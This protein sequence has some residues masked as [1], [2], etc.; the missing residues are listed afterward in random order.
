MK[1]NITIDCRSVIGHRSKKEIIQKVEEFTGF[2]YFQEYNE[3]DEESYPYITVS[4]IFSDEHQLGG[5]D[6]PYDEEVIKWFVI[7]NHRDKLQQIF[8]RNQE[9]NEELL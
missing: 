2:S 1:S 7:K 4:D 9:Y 5:S 6:K 8:D 3:W